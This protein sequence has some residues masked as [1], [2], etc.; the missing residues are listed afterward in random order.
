MMLKNG[1]RIFGCAFLI[2]GMLLTFAPCVKADSERP[3]QDYVK[4]TEN[5]RYVFVMLAP[6]RWSRYS[7][8]EIRK[9]YKQSGLYRNDGS[10]T[11]LWT[12][13]WFSYGVYPS[14]DGRHVVRMGPWAYDVNQLAVAF[15]K[16]GRELRAYSIKDL[17]RDESKLRHTVS[18]FFWQSSLRY[19]D[20]RGMLFLTTV[21]DRSYRFSVK[22]GEIEPEPDGTDS[23]GRQGVG[24][25]AGPA[26]SERIVL[27]EPVQV[28]AEILKEEPPAEGMGG[29][30][31]L[32]ITVEKGRNK[33]DRRTFLVNADN[34]EAAFALIRKGT[35][36]K[37]GYLFVRTECGG[38]NMWRC[39][40]DVVF[41]LR[42]EGLRVLGDL[43]AGDRDVPAVSWKDGYFWDIYDKFEMNGLTDH[44]AAPA[45]LVALKDEGGVLKA[46]LRR[47]WLRNLPDF[48]RRAA[49]IG[50]LKAGRR[51]RDLESAILANTV[52]ARYCAQKKEA[53]KMERLAVRHFAPAD[54]KLFRELIAH[55]EAGEYPIISEEE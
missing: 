34:R 50:A 19:D 2:V 10:T 43:F 45:F 7:T 6:E 28:T 21:D 18:H 12:V 32:K 53:E 33:F 17:V 30:C 5:G 16:D 23:S 54:L 35:R 42:G 38:G 40:R 3:P 25:N 52:L 36:W 31:E 39:N 47:T 41:S 49:E 27:R 51:Q 8:G 11:P 9:T 14:S 13:D 1:R 4:E 20:K 44:V 55:V 37:D 48:T 24:H 22:T 15:Y 29:I 26:Q 46:D